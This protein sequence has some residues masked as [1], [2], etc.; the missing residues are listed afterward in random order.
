M[1]RIPELLLPAGGFDAGIAAFEGGADAV[2][3]GLAEFSARKQARNFDDLEY[4]RFL[5]RAR[6]L[7]KKVFVA[8]NTV[9]LET[10][11]EVLCERLTF[12]CRFAPDAVIAQDWGLVRLLHER[13][14]TLP[15]HAST[16]TAIQDVGA[17]ALAAELGVERVVLPRESSPLDLSLLSSAHPA[18]EFEVFVHGALC[19]SF[20]GLCLASGLL[21]GRSGNRGDCAQLCR[22]WYTSKGGGLRGEGYW[23]SMGDLSLVDRLRELAEAGAASL[24]VE[25]RMKS[26]EYVHA[27]ASL[28]RGALDRLSGTGPD[29]A[30]L[31]RRQETLLT[32]FSRKT[33]S[34]W[35]GHHAGLSIIDSGYPGHRGRPLGEVEEIGPSG[36]VVRL[37]TEL[38]LRDGLQIL[39]VPEEGSLIESLRFSAVGLTEVGSGKRLVRAGA[40]ARV[41]VPLPEKGTSGLSLLRPGAEI[42]RISSRDLDRRVSSQEEYPP[43]L[44]LP[45]TTLCLSAGGEGRARF[46]LEVTLPPFT[47]L[48]ESALS[49]R[50]LDPEELPLD[51]ARQG[52]GF[53]RAL[54]IFAE[55]GDHDF[56]LGSP[57]LRDEREPGLAESLPLGDLFIPPSALKRLKNRLYEAASR[58]LAAHARA[59]A[60]SSAAWSP[61]ERVPTGPG[62]SDP[63]WPAAY[64]DRAALVF[65][66]ERIETGFPFATPALLA[67]GRDLPEY[68]GLHWLA[69]AP[70]V[71]DLAE[72]KDL[73]AARIETEIGAGHRLMVGLGALHHLSWAREFLSRAEAA[74]QGGS[75]GFFA[76]IHLYVANRLALSTFDSL[77]GHLHF[78]YAWLE[79]DPG[80]DRLPSLDREWKEGQIGLAPVG[81]GL[82]PPL[83]LSKACLL[84]HHVAKGHCPSPCGKRLL[85]LLEDRNRRYVALVEDCVSLLFALPSGP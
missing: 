80:S 60:R 14:P 47:G 12:L 36:F 55:S 28:Y 45:E 84:R 82:N 4:R 62:P 9:I 26:P 72:Y 40:G 63:S 18:M 1:I 57:A 71:M 74:G 23:F 27:A 52:G 70:L 30:E 10:E 33:T 25:G 34:G 39:S 44:E 69:L 73:V 7:G 3:L 64:P 53:Q 35:A 16:Q 67:S 38:T 65:P 2:Y 31:A 43:A 22:S 77:V 24:K 66:D 49:L 20:S 37:E 78:A 48:P 17:V 83:F 51:R 32:T 61:P 21:L 29:E 50:L 15:I 6:S 58:G 68:G 8:I 81:P 46:A 59:V 85:T 42:Q 11:I 41:F 56:R 54:E 5:A 79:E 75:L 19:Y 76:D 13:F